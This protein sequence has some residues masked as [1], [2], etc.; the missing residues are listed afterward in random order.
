MLSCCYSSCKLNSS[1]IPPPALST[2]LHFSFDSFQLLEAF[3]IHLR[4]FKISL[5]TISRKT[6]PSIP[7]DAG[8]LLKAN[9]AMLFLMRLFLPIA[10]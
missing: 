9:F 6:T 5:L 7:N 10:F 1:Q 4:Q 3:L 2:S 8:K